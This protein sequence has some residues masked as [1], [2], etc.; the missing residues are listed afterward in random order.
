MRD[1][2][3]ALFQEYRDDMDRTSA[4]VAR[5]VV[6]D[7]TAEQLQAKYLYSAYCRFTEDEGGKPINVTAFGRAMSKKF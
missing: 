4:F 6:R 2:P 3:T 1:V 7:E 5:C